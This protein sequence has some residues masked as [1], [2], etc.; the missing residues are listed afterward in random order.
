MR[1][2]VTVPIPPVNAGVTLSRQTIAT[3]DDAITRNVVGVK[4]SCTT[5]GIEFT[6]DIN[7]APQVIVDAF[8]LGQFTAPFEVA[9]SV[10]VNVQ[11]SFSVQNTTGANLVAGDF[12]TV[13]Y[14]T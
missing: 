1:R 7:T 6:F 10:P 8:V 14:E 9:Y 12:V 13:V 3:Q 4:S 5:K 2:V 11:I